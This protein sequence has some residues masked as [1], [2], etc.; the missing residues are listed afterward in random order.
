MSSKIKLA[1]FAAA[2]ATLLSVPAFARAPH[3]N[4]HHPNVSYAR[5]YSHPGVVAGR[6]FYGPESASIP[7]S[8][9]FRHYD[10]IFVL[11]P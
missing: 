8:N 2:A 6:R 4:R 1:L 3:A 11:D 9:A 5:T 10:D 7:Q